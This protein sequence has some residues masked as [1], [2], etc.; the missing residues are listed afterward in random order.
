[1]SI[2]NVRHWQ[3]NSCGDGVLGPGETCDPPRGPSTSGGLLCGATCQVPACGNGVID[4]GETCDPPNRSTCDDSCESIPIVCGNDIVQPGETCDF[5]STRAC[6]NCA[7]TTC[8][9]CWSI[10]GGGA[11]VCSGLDLP[12]TVACNQ[13]VGCA[14]N[15]PASCGTIGYGATACYCGT[16]GTC[17]AGALGPCA[18]QFNALAHSNDP[19]VVLSLITNSS[20][21]VERVAAAASAFGKAPCGLICYMQ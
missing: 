15:N 2:T 1:M 17:S 5:P 10:Y 19:S 13:L 9:T 3:P 11:T 7:L 4:P 14:L 16:D 21:P 8:G 12:D 20:S 6:V 18:A